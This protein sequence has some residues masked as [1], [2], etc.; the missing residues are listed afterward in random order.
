M[1]QAL[2]LACAVSLT[3]TAQLLAQRPRLGLDTTAADSVRIQS[4][5]PYARQGGGQGLYDLYLPPR[6]S[7]TPLPVVVFVSSSN[8]RANTQHQGW[9]RLIAAH[10]L[11]AVTYDARNG[12]LAA[13]LDALMAALQSGGAGAEVDAGRAG[14]WLA[15][16]I[17]YEG[18]PVSMEPGRDYLRAVAA[19]YGAPPRVDFRL[20]RPALLVR[21]GMD[22][23][24][25][26]R[27]IDSMAFRALASNAPITI[28]NHPSG[29]HPFEETDSTAL[30][31]YV[32]AQTIAFFRATL[33]PA[34]HRDLAAAATAE[35][36]VGRAMYAGDGAVAAAI[37]QRLVAADTGNAELWR[38]LA[39]AQLKARQHREAVA[40]YTRARELRHWRRGDIAVGVISACWRVGDRECVQRWIAV[41]PASWERPMLLQREEL[42][43]LRGDAEFVALLTGRD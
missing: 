15:S 28:I 25:L 8:L 9:A 17:A 11:A 16:G 13:D 7:R 41:L 37:L 14:W 32:I 40:S 26:N 27:A 3:G 33:Q 23:L 31:R 35:G 6:R 1:R 10:G 42:A 22:Q 12:Q 2:V 18:L 24:A 4:G 20:D 38:Q 21:V 39:M 5:L 43:D 29:Y 34:Y 19:Y 36:A 30:A